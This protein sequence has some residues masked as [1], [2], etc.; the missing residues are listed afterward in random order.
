MF[1]HFLKIFLLRQQSEY[2]SAEILKLFYQGYVFYLLL[3]IVPLHVYGDPSLMFTLNA[4]RSYKNVLPGSFCIVNSI[5][6][7]NMCLKRLNRIKYN[8]VVLI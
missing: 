1:D 6:H 4:Y 2:V 5:Q 8:K 3:I 7:L